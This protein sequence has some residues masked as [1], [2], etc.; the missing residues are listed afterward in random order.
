MT[1]AELLALA[2]ELREGCPSAMYGD[3]RRYDVPAFERTAQRAATALEQIARAE[4]VAWREIS[5]DGDW[6]YSS[7]PWATKAE[8]LYAAQPAGGAELDRELDEFERSSAAEAVHVLF[9]Y[10]GWK[11]GGLGSAAIETVSRAEQAEALLREIDQY[12]VLSAGMKKRIRAFIGEH[13]AS[14]PQGT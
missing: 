5:N 6:T 13:S 14:H 11:E 8:P 7:H 2:A 1:P 4:P 9:N 3:Q 12:G 10:L